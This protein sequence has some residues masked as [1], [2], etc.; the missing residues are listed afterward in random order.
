LIL[1]T[2]ENELALR[3]DKVY[4]LDNLELKDIR[5]TYY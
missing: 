5:W 4:K 1:V 3:C 2:H